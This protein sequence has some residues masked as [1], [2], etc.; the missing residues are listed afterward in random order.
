[1][2]IRGQNAFFILR[3]LQTGKAAV[4]GS[5]IQLA[6]RAKHR[7]RLTVV[8]DWKRERQ[9]ANAD[10]GHRCTLIFSDEFMEEYF[11]ERASLRFPP[12]ASVQKTGPT[13]LY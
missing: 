13:S 7:L 11:N 8:V 12:I 9:K 3:L 1:M 4:E 5:R 6:D 2:C 10:M